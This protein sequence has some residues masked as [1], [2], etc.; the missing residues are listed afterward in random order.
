MSH[1]ISNPY[2]EKDM[3]IKFVCILYFKDRND[4]KV[5]NEGMDP[6]E[7]WDILDYKAFHENVVPVILD[8]LISNSIKRGYI[9]FNYA[10]KKVVLTQKG[11]DWGGHSCQSVSG[12]T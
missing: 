8:K 10:T 11:R 1:I 5:V 6:F 2:A 7:I 3:T 12:V 9:E 4:P